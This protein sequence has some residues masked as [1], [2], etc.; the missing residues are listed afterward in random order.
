MSCAA[1]GSK[2]SSG[3]CEGQPHVQEPG[4]DA[5]QGVG[6]RHRRIVRDVDHPNSG[7][8]LGCVGS[9]PS[10]PCRVRGEGCPE[11]SRLIPAVGGVSLAL[12]AGAG[13]QPHATASKTEHK[14]RRAARERKEV[15]IIKGRKTGGEAERPPGQ[16][17]ILGHERWPPPRRADEGLGAWPPAVTAEPTLPAKA[18]LLPSL[19]RLHPRGE[20]RKLGEQ[21]MGGPGR[22]GLDAQQQ[23]ADAMQVPGQVQAVCSRSSPR[24]SC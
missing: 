20:R 19:A 3:R 12:G 6:Q 23:L 9:W 11:L 16:E 5:G 15:A 2:R 13:L 17:E 10:R 1:A 21:R 14:N 7:R 18:A 24:P 8:Q 22:I 4:V